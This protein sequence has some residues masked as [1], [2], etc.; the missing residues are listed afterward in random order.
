MAVRCEL[1]E[2]EEA[3]LPRHSW[4]LCLKR[5][6]FRDARVPRNPVLFYP[7]SAVCDVNTVP[8][9]NYLAHED[10]FYSFLV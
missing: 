4:F 6:G 1:G 2:G 9:L 10:L 5:L 8:F 3:A 7:E